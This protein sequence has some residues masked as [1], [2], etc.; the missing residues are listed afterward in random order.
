MQAY[1]AGCSLRS[2]AINAN[3]WMSSNK[4]FKGLPDASSKKQIKICNLV[5]Q[6]AIWIVA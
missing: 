1:C 4:Q 3:I 2:L 5:W 6:D